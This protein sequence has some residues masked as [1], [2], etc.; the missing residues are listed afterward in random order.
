ATETATASSDTLGLR[1]VEQENSHGHIN[2]WIQPLPEMFPTET[3]SPTGRKNR[4]SMFEFKSPVLE[5]DMNMNVARQRT[6]L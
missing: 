5:G 2:Q 3:V 1:N 6:R 4:A